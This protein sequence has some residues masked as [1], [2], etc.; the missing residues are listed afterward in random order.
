MMRLRFVQ[1]VR[2]CQDKLTLFLPVVN[3]RSDRVPQHWGILPLVN[4]SWRSTFKQQRWLCRSSGKILVSHIRILQFS[5]SLITLLATCS[6]V[7]V[8][9]HHL[10][11]SISTAPKASSR[12]LSTTSAV[13]FK[14]AIQNP[15]LFHGAKLH[16]II[17]TT[18]FTLAF[19]GI[20]IWIFVVFNFCFLLHTSIALKL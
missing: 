16:K 17:E 12:S 1:C 4:Q 14:Y 7:V 6:A 3:R 15:F 13:L 11:P 10:G 9:P 5:C 2:A 18:K 20:L 8:L 19:C